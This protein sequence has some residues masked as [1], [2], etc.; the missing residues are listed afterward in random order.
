MRELMYGTVVVMVREVRSGVQR[1]VPSEPTISTASILSSSH[2]Y[3][4]IQFQGESSPGN[5][6]RF[7]K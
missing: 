1:M 2:E 6:K 4:L 7:V 5:E 3:F